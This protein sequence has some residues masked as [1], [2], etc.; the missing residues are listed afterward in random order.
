MNTI[1]QILA[2]LK[3]YGSALVGAMLVSIAAAVGT[4]KW[5]EPVWMIALTAGLS[6]LAFGA[7]MAHPPVA[8]LAMKL[9]LLASAKM[10]TNDREITGTKGQ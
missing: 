1:V 3:T 9:R 6:F 4:G 2:I 5:E 7:A 10:I 8:R